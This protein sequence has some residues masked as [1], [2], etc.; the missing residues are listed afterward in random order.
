MCGK[1]HMFSEF[2]SFVCKYFAP[3]FNTESTSLIHQYA[4]DFAFNRFL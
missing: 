3:F 4:I 1:R 2:T